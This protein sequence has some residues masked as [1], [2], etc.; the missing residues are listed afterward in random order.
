MRNASHRWVVR[1]AQ[2]LLDFRP[3]PRIML[4]PLL[5]LLHRLPHENAQE[6]SSRAVLRFRSLGESAFQVVIDSESEGRLR[7]QGTRECL[8]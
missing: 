4:P 2:P 7:H 8:W 6:L 1:L 3:K 5:L